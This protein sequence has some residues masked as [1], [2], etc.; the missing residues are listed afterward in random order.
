M[1]IKTPTKEERIA[2]HK[3]GVK[4]ILVTV[5]LGVLAGILSSPYFLSQPV[6]A[7][8]T[9]NGG[10]D[11]LDYPALALHHAVV[12]TPNASLPAGSFVVPGT[13]ALLGNASLIYN[14]PSAQIPNAAVRNTNAIIIP[15]HASVTHVNSSV[16]LSNAQVILSDSS[17]IPANASVLLTNGVILLPDPADTQ[18]ASVLL[19]SDTVMQTNPR[20]PNNGSFAFLI[21]AL[22]IYVQKYI[23]PYLGIDSKRFGF[24][25]WFF[26]AFMTFCFWFVTWTLL[27]NGP[28]PLFGPLF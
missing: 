22:L 3:R 6:Y 19:G 23:F 10:A 15:A 8:I 28:A 25:D 2:L 17:D 26:L 24:K 14:N 1:E 12:V 27:L 21:L 13:A 4:M 20:A 18:N 5:L 11:F 9:Q 7:P 16:L